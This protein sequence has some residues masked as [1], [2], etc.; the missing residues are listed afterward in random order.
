MIAIS[1]VDNAGIARV[2]AVPLDRLP[3]LAAWGV[4]CSPSFDYFRFD[5]WLAAPADGTA[6]VG[7][8]RLLPDLDRVVPLAASPG[9]A[10]TPGDRWLQGGSPHPGCS[11]HALR[12]ASDALSAD[13]FALLSA[14]EI[15][16]VLTNAGDP[17][18]TSA[19]GGA[20][21]GLDR[22]GVAD[23]YLRDL[24]GALRAQD[25]QVEQV[26]PEYA[27]GQFELSVSADSP[28][29]AADT[30]VLV[31]HTIR[32]VGQRH[33]FR[34][35]FSPRVSLDGVGNGGHVHLSLWRDGRNLMA[36]DP[37]DERGWPRGDAPRA[38][39][40]SAQGSAF[41]A[42]ILR[43]LPALLAVGAPSAVSYQRL[44]PSHWSGPYACWGHENREAALRLIAD[45]TGSAPWA[46][47]L[48]V[49]CVDLT[50][51]PYLLLA[52]LIAAGR[53]GHAARLRLPPSVDVDPAS[54]SDL[55][56]TGRGIHRL[57]TSLAEA[58][59][60]FAGDP[61]LT[62]ALGRQLT[63]AILAVRRSEIDHFATSSDAEIVQ[64]ARWAY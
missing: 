56:R 30:S 24:V 46:A 20:A 49:K 32:A 2:K 39:D 51:N 33:G 28:V 38:R 21:Y 27:A 4:G 59:T 57:P 6:P 52:S 60:L 5:D 25:V 16:W 26:H 44:V 10:W 43:H 12:R 55:E 23:A 36:S 62:E 13:A 47:N 34:T 35:S 18:A 50:A 64:A 1:F 8:L 45:P 3:H 15:E 19:V 31:R 22:L 53:S 41:A 11:R 61:V 9:W 48:E 58:L 7:D 42:G 54:L 63:D 37:P 14:W 17:E 29:R 40:I